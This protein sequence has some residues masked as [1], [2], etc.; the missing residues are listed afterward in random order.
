[1]NLFKKTILFRRYTDNSNPYSIAYNARSY[2]EP[3]HVDILCVD[4]GCGRFSVLL[5]TLGMSIDL[6]FFNTEAEARSSFDDWCQRYKRS[7]APDLVFEKEIEGFEAFKVWVLKRY[8]KH[9][10]Y[11]IKFFLISRNPEMRSDY[12]P[13]GSYAPRIVIR[14]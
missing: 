5:K 1:M 3:Y 6:R 14:T 7:F 10:W 11:E 13:F 4:H 9:Y 8:L 2:T 12:S